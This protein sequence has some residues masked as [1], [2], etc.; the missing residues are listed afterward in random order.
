[1]LDLCELA[2]TKNCWIM[3]DI[4]SGRIFKGWQL[5]QPP[6]T[7]LVGQLTGI[8]S[9]LP[10]LCFWL[11]APNTW[12]SLLFPGPVCPRTQHPDCLSLRSSE[13]HL[14]RDSTDRSAP[15]T[16]RLRLLQVLTPLTSPPLPTSEPLRKAAKQYN[17]ASY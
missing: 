15:N 16:L 11:Q 4:I 6:C 12:N 17:R 1:M 10:P 13:L 7:G 3:Q 5:K 8:D 2:L 14:R 9:I